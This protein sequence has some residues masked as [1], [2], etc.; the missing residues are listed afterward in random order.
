MLRRGFKSKA[1][2]IALEVRGELGLKPYAPLN[3]FTLAEHLAI[4][5]WPL[6]LLEEI[7]AAIE[8][9]KHNEPE[10]FSAITVFDGWK[11]TIVHNDTHSP[12]RQNSNIA[13][14]LAHCLLEHPPVEA[15][16]A[17]GCRTLDPVIEAE[18]AWL[19][20]TLLVPREAAVSVMRRRL[21]D[22]QAAGLYGV[23]QQMLIYRMNVTG[24]GRLPRVRP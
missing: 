4:P 10:A 9:F 17:Y 6:A 19:G 1:N 7:T 3:P 20:G 15:F 18:A 2:A 21:S 16:D 12:V 22:V 23:S 5:V 13:H 11:R 24:V 8:H 14:E